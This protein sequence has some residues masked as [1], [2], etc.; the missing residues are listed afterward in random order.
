MPPVY[1]ASFLVSPLIPSVSETIISTQV[2]ACYVRITMPLKG[3]SYSVLMDSQPGRVG[4]L[5]PQPMGMGVSGEIVLPFVLW[6][7]NSTTLSVQSSECPYGIKDHFHILLINSIT[8]THLKRPSFP[9][10]TLPGLS[11]LLLVSLPI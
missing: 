10:F 6:G 2:S 11:L 5:R 3:G 4:K 8:H 7:D 9:C 1:L